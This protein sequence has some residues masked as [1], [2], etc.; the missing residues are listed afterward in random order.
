L[1]H[2][3]CHAAAAPAGSASTLIDN[4]RTVQAEL[5][6]VHVTFS[7]DDYLASV[8]GLQL[9]VRRESAGFAELGADHLHLHPSTAWQT[10][11]RADE[12][13]PLGVILNG[14]RLGAYPAAEVRKALAALYRP[15]GRRSFAIHS[16]LGHAPE[17]TVAILKALELGEGFFWLHDFASLCAGFH[18]L[19]DDVEDCS[20]PASTSAACGICGYGPLRARH[21]EAHRRLF[22][23]LRLT[24]VAPAETTLRFWQASTRLKPAGA[25]VLP[26]AR[27]VA[28]GPVPAPRH[29]ALR[30]AFT[31]LPAPLKGWPIFKA[32]AERF[33]DDPR[34]EFHHLGARRD[35]VA[36]AAFHRVTSGPERP[37]AMRQ[38]LAELEID[39]ALIWPLCRETF[40]LTAYEAAAAGAAVVTGPDS[41]N[42]AAFVAET[43]LGQVLP[44]EEA[45]AAA[46]EDGAILELARARRGAVLH[47]LK[48]SALTAD[49]LAEAVPA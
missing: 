41:G 14:T 44:T 30:V 49:L 17:E 8:G 26:H 3:K 1:A 46:F 28:R 36:R 16:L 43:G 22:Q 6:D 40:S 13:G 32:L 33:A 4:I 27:L 23:R 45:L 47:D 20:A 38:T 9:S 15:G 19:R 34:Y 48:F 2:A 7:H 18:L 42:V 35:P 11:R 39:V 29:Q 25:I 31:G 10:V 12:P 24:V 5:R 21:V 37:E